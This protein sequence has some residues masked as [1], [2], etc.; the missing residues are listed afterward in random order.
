MTAMMIPMPG[1]RQMQAEVSGPADGPPLIFHHTTPGSARPYRAL[2]DAAD[3]HGLRLVTFARAGYG[4]STRL[5][6]RTVADA[7]A[8]VEALID[9]LAIERCLVLGWSGGGPHALATAA[10]LPGRVTAVAS[11]SGF[12]PSGAQ[13]LD[14]L[15]GMGQ[16]NVD[17][18]Q[19]ALQ[20]EDAITP[21][22]AAAAAALATATGPDLLP[23]LGTLLSDSDRAFLAPAETAQDIAATVS[24]GVQRGAAGWIDDDLAFVKPWGF[25]VD[26]I[27]VPTF[28]WQGG[29]DLMVPYAH[30][31]WLAG[32]VPGAVTHLMKNEGHFSVALGRM[33]EVLRELAKTF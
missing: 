32:H 17:D 11:V 29:Q 4:H 5:A 15:A 33:A 2:K 14:F 9:H 23:S 12:A 10:L 3:E 20:G 13:G 16:G 1:G 19:L 18:F 7:A 6:G 30:G 27:A 31:E 8:D 26:Q 22:H 25:A 28:L 24:A 21:G